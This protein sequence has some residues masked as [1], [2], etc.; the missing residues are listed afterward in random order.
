MYNVETAGV[1]QTLQTLDNGCGSAYEAILS[2]CARLAYI[3][4]DWP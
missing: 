4:P 2:A 1:V 3:L